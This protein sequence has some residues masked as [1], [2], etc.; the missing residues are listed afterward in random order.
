MSTLLQLLGV[1]ALSFVELWAAVPAG[2]A[3][4]LPAVLVWATTVAGAMFCV[5]VVVY[6]GD[7]LRSWLV[8]RLGHGRAAGE[9]GRARRVWERYGVAGWGLVG[10]LVLGVPLAAAVGVGMGAPRRKLVV[11]LGA[12]AI[13]WTTVLTVA[14]AV[15]VDAVR[16]LA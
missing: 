5:V 8:R 13:L 1:L 7:K 12:G 4:G 15:G 9:G 11:W 3:L 2:I 16:R 14:A 6:A 10:P